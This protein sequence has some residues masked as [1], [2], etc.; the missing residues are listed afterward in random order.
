VANKYRALLEA[1]V[2]H[3]GRSLIFVH[4]AEHGT[5]VNGH[6]VIS[7]GL[8]TIST[9]RVFFAN[10][11][12]SDNGCLVGPEDPVDAVFLLDCRY[13]HTA[14]RTL[15]P[16]SRIVEVMATSSAD[17]P[18]PNVGSVRSSFT[19]QFANEVAYRK[20]RGDRSIVLSDVIESLRLKS[21]T[22]TKPTH[23]LRLGAS[24]IRLPFPEASPH[25]GLL[26]ALL[27]SNTRAIPAILTTPDIA[28]P[29]E[30]SIQETDRLIRV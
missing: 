14:T 18:M 20:G 17:S 24:S 1:S 22:K 30:K 8:E 26:L 21:V 28:P 3:P 25:D 6:L 5:E 11:L 29:T 23:A 2:L 13:S 27:V 19:A 7:N 16:V 10:I 4:Y 12:G 9:E 15:A